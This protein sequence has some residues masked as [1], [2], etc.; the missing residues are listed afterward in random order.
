MLFNAGGIGFVK[1]KGHGD[2]L[3][4]ADVMGESNRLWSRVY[5]LSSLF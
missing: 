5:A 4:P 1:M 2:L 3:K